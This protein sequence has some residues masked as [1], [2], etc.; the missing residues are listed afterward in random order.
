[1]TVDLGP[2]LRK[3]LWLELDW[4]KAAPALAE[5]VMASES[6]T[7]AVKA[8]YLR[9]LAELCEFCVLDPQIAAD[10]YG[11][12]FQ[13]DR[14]QSDVLPRMRRLCE[15]IGRFDHAA[16]T[17]ELEF[18]QSQ[19]QRFH[20][21]AGQSWLDAGEPD[22]A[23][24]P[25]LAADAAAPGNPHIMAALEV[26]RREWANPEA[27]AEQLIESARGQGAAGVIPALQA[28]RILNML[29][30]DDERFEEALL[31]CLAA[32]PNLPSACNLMEVFLLE[33]DRL[34]DLEAHF[35]LRATA[36]PS[37]AAASDILVGGAS[38][39]LRSGAGAEGTR[40]FAEAIARASKAGYCLPGALALLR[41]VVASGS[42]G[43]LHVMTY[44]ESLRELPAS[45]DEQ[46]GLAIFCAQIAWHAQKNYAEAQRWMKRIAE[47]CPEHPL[48]VDFQLAAAILE[49][50][51]AP[52]EVPREAAPAPPPAVSADPKRRLPRVAI[53]AKL[54]LKMHMRDRMGISTKFDAVTRNISTVGALV[55]CEKDLSLDQVLEVTL[56]VP[57]ASGLSK[58]RFAVKARVAKRVPGAGVGLEWVDSSFDFRSAI[59]AIPDP[60]A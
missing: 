34:E 45:I 28:A 16:R 50:D 41:A 17:A 59:S 3:H 10:L 23:I 21:I 7:S 51:E 54:E 55:R 48:L 19:E 47:H 40:V 25:L 30:F 36:A 15:A 46:V 1:M 52:A 33:N 32:Q 14:S 6:M 9:R 5:Q 38:L 58:R 35:Y 26:A 57:S 39:L 49:A 20:A 43:R 53:E 27:H 22:R 11:A 13:A 8:P 44:A 42:E 12:S 56:Q 2:E 37:D 18:R 29:D 4:S 31:I 24:K 60:T